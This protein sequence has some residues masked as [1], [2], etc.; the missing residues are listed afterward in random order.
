MLWIL[1]LI[2][3]LSTRL[4]QLQRRGPLFPAPSRIKLGLYILPHWI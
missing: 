2:A 1:V 3:N 4:V